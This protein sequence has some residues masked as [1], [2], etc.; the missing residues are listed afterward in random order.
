MADVRN[1]L[2]QVG[3]SPELLRA[4]PTSALQAFDAGDPEPLRRACVRSQ[5]PG[6]D[7]IA[8]LYAGASLES[9]SAHPDFPWSAAAELGL[10]QLADGII[11]PALR[12]TPISLPAFPDRPPPATGF[13]IS[14]HLPEGPLP[15]EH[16]MA[17]GGSS[18]TL[19]RLT[20]RQP[21]DRAL[22]LGCGSGY[23]TLLLT[24]HAADVVATD[25]NPRASRA[26][27]LTLAL[28]GVPAAQ[29]LNTSLFDHVPGTFDLVVSS[30]PFV[31]A[32][33]FEHAYRDSPEVADSLIPL[34]VTGISARLRPG[35]WGVM[36]GSWLHTHDQD[37]RLRVQPWLEVPA[38][39]TAWLAERECLNVSDYIDLW[40]RDA[41]QADTAEHREQ[42]RGYLESFHTSAVGFG[43]VVVH[44]PRSTAPPSAVHS[45]VEDVSEAATIPTGAEVR[46]EFDRRA[47][48]PDAGDILTGHPRVTSSPPQWRG[49]VMVT[50][51]V[52]WW[53]DHGELYPSLQ[54][55]LV[56][57]AT[58]VAEDQYD[59]L[60]AW[61][62]GVRDLMEKGFATL[63]PHRPA[64]ANSLS[65]NFGNDI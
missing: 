53:L 31:M 28:S 15:A 3:F 10:V 19:A 65:P 41:H 40:R 42:W 34:L 56:D 1:A 62:T 11:T 27:S 59:V 51:A 38:G 60:V 63:D 24:T 43:W 20:P 47:A 26:T 52:H 54:D 39:A 12:V 9:E 36:L 22:D 48:L 45:W 16:V 8:V 25:T 29:V 14:D 4:L 23:Q 32:P 50:P 55:A 5:H 64:D 58:A 44:Q 61:L 46:A 2:Q 57:C 17:P 6:A 7:L 33:A 13:V 18:E 35:G 49:P 37:W 21:I 30:P